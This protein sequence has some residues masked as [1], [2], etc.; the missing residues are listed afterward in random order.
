[1][2]STTSTS[3]PSTPSVLSTSLWD[4]LPTEIKNLTFNAT[5]IPTR[6]INNQPLTESE[7]KANARDIWI[8]VINTNS[9]HLDL[10]PL[11]KS[12]FPTILN[13]LDQITSREAYY[14]LCKP[15]PDLVGIRPLQT[16]FEP[17][18][19]WSQMNLD[20]NPEPELVKLLIHIFMRQNWK[21]ELDGLN[22]LDQFYLCIEAGSF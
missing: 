21:D 4:A 11:P 16:L 10:T 22:D 13:G 19:F 18:T 5:H 14:Q 6:L 3:S 12:H 15:R 2:P 20:R 9:W 1:M 8:A 17:K 7:I